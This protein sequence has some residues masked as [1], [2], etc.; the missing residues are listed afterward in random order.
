MENLITPEAGSQ[1][2][3]QAGE[4]LGE[5]GAVSTETQPQDSGV[6]TPS[7]PFLDTAEI[8][9]REAGEEPQPSET[10]EGE[11]EGGQEESPNLPE[12]VLEMLPEKFRNADDPIGALVKSY[13]E[14]E[15]TLSQLQNQLYQYEQALQQLIMQGQQAQPAENI[16]DI[17]DDEVIT[18]KELKEYLNRV[19][20]QQLMPMLTQAELA[21]AQAQLRARHP[22]YDRIINS[23][24]F[25]R[26]VRSLP[27]QLVQVGSYDPQVADWIISQYK[28]QKA[29]EA[30]AQHKAQ[31]ANVRREKLNQLSQPQTTKPAGAKTFRASGLRKLMMENPEEYAR[32]QP[33]IIRAIQEGRFIND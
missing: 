13:S 21:Q 16:E 9:S 33:E 19:L 7:D 26:F 32:L 10:Q 27:P 3:P 29:Q 11:Q 15:K 18:G 2:Q 24:D 14:A 1:P 31:E 23:E 30:Q 4:A 17:P 20:Q 8:V 25:S 6:Y 28:A 5:G 12:N 22:D